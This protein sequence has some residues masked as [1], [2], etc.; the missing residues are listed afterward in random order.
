M[1]G[2]DER[3]Q[4]RRRCEFSAAD[5]AASPFLKYALLRDPDDDELSHRTLDQHQSVAGR[6]RVETWIRRV[7]KR[8]RG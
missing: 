3:R 8:P 1:I 7:D 4:R 6:P 5:C 2:V